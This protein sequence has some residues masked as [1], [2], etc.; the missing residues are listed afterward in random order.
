MLRIINPNSTIMKGRF[1]H[2]LTLISIAILSINFAFA[3]TPTTP[4]STKLNEITSLSGKKR[5][6][7]KRYVVCEVI[8]NMLVFDA[9]FEY[10]FISVSVIGEDNTTPIEGTITPLQ[11]YIITPASMIGEYSIQ[12]TTDGGAV[13]EGSITL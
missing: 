6:P 12:C 10:E 9:N 7:S 13:Y 4:S 3:D 1:H 8:N 2:Y 5:I 11:P